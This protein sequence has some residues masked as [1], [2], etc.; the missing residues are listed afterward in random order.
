MNEAD[1]IMIYDCILLWM[2][3]IVISTVLFN[4]LPE[5][6]NRF[7]Y[8]TSRYFNRS[9][10]NIYALS[11]TILGMLAA[12]RVILDGAYL[13][14][15]HDIRYALV[16]NLLVLNGGYFLDS[17]ITM[18]GGIDESNTAIDEYTSLTQEIV[19]HALINIL[20]RFLVFNIFIALMAY[21]LQ[22][23]RV[24]SEKKEKILR[25]SETKSIEYEIRTDK[26]KAEEAAA[27]VKF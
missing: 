2:I 9:V 16:R 3:I 6:F 23:A 18:T 19:Q 10:F 22:E 25:H 13:Y 24:E 8:F 17:G 1:A 12:L 14:N 7:L 11:L 15:V 4:W 26:R 20:Y 5:L 21:Y 27:K